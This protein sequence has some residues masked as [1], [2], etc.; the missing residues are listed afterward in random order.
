MDNRDDRLEGAQGEQVTTKVGAAGHDATS[1]GPTVVSKPR[2]QAP[3]QGG[4]D[5]F[6]GS[7]IDRR[8]RNSRIV[9]GVLIAV[10]ILLAL[11]LIGF[12]S[13]AFG[14]RDDARRPAAEQQGP[15]Q[16]AD[17]GDSTDDGAL[18]GILG[19]TGDESQNGSDVEKD[20]AA[21]DGAADDDRDSEG[22]R[23]SGAQGAPAFTAA[24]LTEIVGEKWSN[25]QRILDAY[26]VDMDSLVLITDDGGQVINP[27]NW[28]V[29]LV[30]DLADSGKVSVH[31]RH[32]TDNWWDTL[33]D[34]V[35][36]VL[37]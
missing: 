2:E 8:L 9:I 13:G 21:S 26:G 15:A 4:Y 1:A 11:T 25:A 24:D 32:D 10:M 37:P 22:S 33:G 28:T 3:F 23:D 6:E 14:V 12:A 7:V 5:A 18:G 30:A 17:E 36:E 16:D 35:Q 27:S 19:G 31:L 20:D 29:T 34:S